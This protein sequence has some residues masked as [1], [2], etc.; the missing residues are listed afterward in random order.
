[1]ETSQQANRLP[2]KGQATREI[3]RASH[4]QPIILSRL[5]SVSSKELPLLWKSW[6]PWFPCSTDGKRGGAVILQDPWCGTSLLNTTMNGTEKNSSPK[7]PKAILRCQGHPGRH[8]ARSAPVTR[9]QQVTACNDSAVSQSQTRPGASALACHWELPFGPRRR[10]LLTWPD[11]QAFRQKFF[12]ALPG[13]ADRGPSAGQRGALP[14]S[15]SSA[16]KSNPG[17]AKDT[18]THPPPE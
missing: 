11:R 14:K 12:S 1:M 17:R 8:P 9:A 2:M 15:Y 10:T 3:L 5:V 4:W 13:D 6:M 16:S 18:H 7:P